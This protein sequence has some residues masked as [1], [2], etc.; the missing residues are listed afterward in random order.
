MNIFRN[1]A[2]SRGAA[3]AGTPAD[4]AATG[5]LA[6]AARRANAEARRGSRAGGDRSRTA[7]SP[8]AARTAATHAR[9]VRGGDYPSRAPRAGGAGR[10]GSAAHSGR[11]SREG[12]RAR[13]ARNGAL[14][15]YAS[16]NRVVRALYTITTGPYRVVF[17][18]LVVVAVGASLYFPLRDLYIAH[19]TG[20]ILRQQYDIRQQYNESLQEDVDQL[21]STEGIEDIARENLGLV[22]PGEI[23]IDVTGL[24]DTSGDASA[25]GDATAGD[26]GAGATDEA[27]ATDGAST[28][29]ASQNSEDAAGSNGA[30]TTD[31]SSADSSG[32]TSSATTDKPSTSAEAA[33]A[34]RAVVDNAPWYVRLLDTIFFFQGTSGQK[35]AS[36]GDG[37]AS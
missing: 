37:S 5:N 17:Y 4:A 27:G 16:D 33:A 21:L 19:R 1:N 11:A 23:A 6:E 20:E 26:E 7:A 9:G 36:T 35:V 34:E 10:P 14:M 3:R 15:R 31:G 28:D 24:D 29:A 18:L 2:S 13:S 30:G 12:A 8:R 22:K 32:D 25:E